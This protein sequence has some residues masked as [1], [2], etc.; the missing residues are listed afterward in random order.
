MA[1]RWESFSTFTTLKA[2]SISVGSIKLTKESSISV[3]ITQRYYFFSFFPPPPFFG[4]PVTCHTALYSHDAL[5]CWLLMYI[6]KKAKTFRFSLFVPPQGLDCATCSMQSYAR[7]VYTLPTSLGGRRIQGSR[8]LSAL[9]TKKGSLPFFVIPAGWLVSAPD[10]HRGHFFRLTLHSLMR[11]STLN[12]GY[13][14]V[15]FFW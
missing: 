15:W 3:F 4:C 9:I 11:F 7:L 6:T 8:S 2:V 1:I 12:L 14:L 10:A 5:S 13:K